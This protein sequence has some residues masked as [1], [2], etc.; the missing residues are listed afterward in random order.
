M[1]IRETL[2]RFVVVAI[3]VTLAM[4]ATAGTLEELFAAASAKNQDYTVLNLDLEL[5]KLRKTKGDIEAKVELDRLQ[6]QSSYVSA[7]ASYRRSV[8]NFYNEV[9][10][11]AF[12]VATA[13]LDAES[14][15]LSLQNALVD[16]ESAGTRFNSGLISEAV[17]KE[18]EI[19]YKTQANN[20]ELALWTLEDSKRIF[21]STT[22]LEWSSALLPE[23]ASFETQASPEQWLSNDTT[24]QLTQV[25][26]KIQDIKTA[27][28]AAN[29][30]AYDRKI[31]ETEQLKAK[32][33]LNNAQSDARR[34]FESGSN[35]LKNQKNL[36]QIRMDEYALKES[37]YE[38]GLRQYESGII[39]SSEKNQRRI[40]LITAHKNLLAAKKN[41]LK[42][43]GSF[44]SALGENPL[45]I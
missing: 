6:A 43:V 15:S 17:F 18:I 45:G 37:A 31:Q 19:A 9:I 1:R 33:S 5:A 44:L 2:R 34:S 21:F 24:V 41:Y 39:S 8:L 35:N 11:A 14:L 4:P 10:D 42:S 38:D 25:A 13:E 16:K 23:I 29:A 22:G 32:V 30:S 36:L 28:L 40:T 27:S 3:L 26:D 20:Y 12:A 7:I